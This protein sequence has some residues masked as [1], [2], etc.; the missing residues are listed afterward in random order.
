MNSA[1]GDAVL[2]EIQ[3]LLHQ[4]VANIEREDAGLLPVNSLWLWGGGEYVIPSLQ[5]YTT[6]MAN[7]PLLR[8]LAG[9]RCQAL[10]DSAEYLP[11]QGNCLLVLNDMD[12]A[13]FERKWVMPLLAMLKNDKVQKLVLHLEQEQGVTRYELHRQ[14]LWKFWR[15]WGR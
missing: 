13:Q 11:K 10:P 1:H 4:H 6:V 7:E 14:D 8:G 2:N 15:T 5:P 3:M 12:A 9:E